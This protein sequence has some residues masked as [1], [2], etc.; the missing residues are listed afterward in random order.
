MGETMIMGVMTSNNGD[1][2]LQNGKSPAIQL[3][4]TIMPLV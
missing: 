2:T 4:L 1:S 3:G